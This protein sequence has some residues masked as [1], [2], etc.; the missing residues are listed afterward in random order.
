MQ[1]QT[2]VAAKLVRLGDVRRLTLGFGGSFKD[3]KAGDN[4]PEPV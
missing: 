2:Y 1:K 4:H 3:I